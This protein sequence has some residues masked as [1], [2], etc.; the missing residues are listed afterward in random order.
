LLSQISIWLPRLRGSDLPPLTS[1]HTSTPGMSSRKRKLPMPP[2]SQ[3]QIREEQYQAAVISMAAMLRLFK[4]EVPDDGDTSLQAMAVR[5]EKIKTFLSQA[6]RAKVRSIAQLRE[7]G[8][9]G[10]DPT[11]GG[12][13]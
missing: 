12:V 9:Q 7:L 1:L 3:D 6:G 4:W 10:D 2:H 13:A 11:E 8:P 5:V